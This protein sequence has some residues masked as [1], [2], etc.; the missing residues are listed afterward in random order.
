MSSLRTRPP[1]PVPAI[2]FRLISCSRARR[3]A[4]GEMRCRSSSSRRCEA[5]VACASPAPS[6]ALV[7]LCSMTGVAACS[8]F[9]TGAASGPGAA[10]AGGDAETSAFSSIIA[11]SAPTGTVSSTL[12]SIFVRRPAMGDGS[13]ALILSVMISARDSSFSTQ[14]PSFLSQD[15]M[16][17][18]ATDSPNR[19]IFTG[20]G[21][22]N[23]FVL[24]V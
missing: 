18:S 2:W 20:V 9:F 10:W 7:S 24:H 8:G 14:S 5:V 21:M 1:A 11:M 6:L 4:R 17:P 22:C 12:T 15:P 3:L 13:S 23:S 16:V 19:G